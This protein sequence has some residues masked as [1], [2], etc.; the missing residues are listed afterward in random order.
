MEMVS[1]VPVAKQARND[2]DDEPL[3]KK[4]CVLLC[5][6]QN[7]PEYSSEHLNYQNFL[8]DHAPRPSKNEQLQSNHVLYFS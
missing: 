1:S 3:L 7:A 2:Y 6:P 5:M 4:L 8:E